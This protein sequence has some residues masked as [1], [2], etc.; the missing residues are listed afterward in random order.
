M[1]EADKLKVE[2]YDQKKLAE[3]YWHEAREGWNKVTSLQ[4]DNQ[5]LRDEV[6]RLRTALEQ[7]GDDICSEFCGAGPCHKKCMAVQAALTQGK[8]GE[9]Q[10]EMVHV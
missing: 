9:G 3:K 10:D 5:T 8:G 2:L 4:T 1:S 6:A 7:A